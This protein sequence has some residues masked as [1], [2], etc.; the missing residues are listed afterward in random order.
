[1]RGICFCLYVWGR[2]GGTVSVL[3]F[4]EGGGGGGATLG[5]GDSWWSGTV[6][7]SGLL[8]LELPVVPGKLNH[9]GVLVILV[10]LVML[11]ILPL[12][13]RARVPR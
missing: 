13:G 9:E 12:L 6:L 11:V 2:R 5:L 1:M 8:D 10:L 3:F 4:W 7:G